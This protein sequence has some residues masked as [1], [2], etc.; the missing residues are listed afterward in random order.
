[1]PARACLACGQLTARPARSGRCPACEAE[2]Y[3]ARP[4]RAV[5]ASPAWRRLSSR[6][7]KAHIRTNGWR[8]PGWGRPAHNSFDLTAD[9]PEA[10]AT[11]GA[12]LPAQPGVLCRSCNGRKGANPATGAPP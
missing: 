8:C 5:Y 7:I 9:H 12:R 3:A 6:T 2:R 11:G 1:M 10:M 4:T